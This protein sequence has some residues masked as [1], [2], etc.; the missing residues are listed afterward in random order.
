MSDAFVPPTTSEA[1]DRLDTP[2]AEAM[3]TQRAVRRLHL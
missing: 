1:L 3:R 2:M